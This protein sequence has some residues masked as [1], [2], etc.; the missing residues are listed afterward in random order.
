MPYD[1][2]VSYSRKDNLQ[3]WVTDLIAQITCDY[4]RF[5]GEDLR[6][7]FDLAEICAM[8]DWRNRILAGL[9]ESNILLLVL[10]PA[11]LASP[12]CE[13]EVVEFLK[14]EHSRAVQGQGVAQV[15]FVEIAGLDSPE[16]ER[17]A[18]AWVTRIRQRNHVDL[19][20][21]YD[22]GAHALQ[23]ADVRTRLD[24]L[25]RSLGDRLSRLRQIA[26]AP[27]NLPAH[28]PRFVGREV[29]MERLHKA[30]GLGQYGVLTAVHG[31]GGLG[32]TALA[33]QYAYGYADF[34]PGGR[35][36]IGC[37]GRR[38]LASAVR[39]LDSDLGIEFSDEEKL[40]DARAARRVLAVLEQRAEQGAAARAGESH[41]PEPRALLVLDNVDD[42]AL[43]QP[44]HTDL[45]SG[46]KWLH[47]LSTTR[48]DPERIGCDDQRYCHVPV[49]ELPPGDALRLIES[50]QPEGRF[51][52]EEQR[53]A[54]GQIVRL[55][56]GF[57]LAVEVVAVHL[58]ERRGRLACAALL[59]RLRREG[60][61]AVARQTTTAVG[62]VEKL[63]SATLAPTFEIL[64]SAE[65]CAATVAALLPPDCV[66][67][68]WIRAVVG[69]RHPE[70]AVDAEPGYD[71]P[72]LTLVNHLIGLRFWQVLEWADGDRTPRILSRPSARSGRC[73]A[74][75]A[76]QSA[77]HR[78]QLGGSRQDAGRLPEGGMA[79]LEL[80]L[81]NPTPV[82]ICRSSTGGSRAG[83][84]LVCGLCR[85]QPQEFG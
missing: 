33:I 56:G 49:D 25:E 2:F 41:P 11:Y 54:A 32:K 80:S 35:W 44:P 76:G 50:Y 7:F 37:A 45:L 29:E 30:A 66:P 62:H 59:D 24:D 51:A 22:D 1:L 21:W 68:P 18:A 27:G 67:L 19:R 83:G 16:F 84:S 23:R 61:D 73:Q 85:H 72:W 12:Y 15:Y 74:V 48:L 20:P 26:N 39:S 52:D 4:R 71:D 78:G 28:N 31:V 3:G 79:E 60:V 36:I 63:M 5:A 42:P 58:R 14:Y 46:R 70:L 6:C 57:T 40:D 82:R 38:S 55:L 9:R 8:D 64:N 81:G 47:V 17:T 65:L 10:S 77:G 13:W 53:A 75:C 69:K 43:L 34:Y